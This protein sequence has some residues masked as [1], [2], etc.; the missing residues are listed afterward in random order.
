M[1]GR[2]SAVIGVFDQTAVFRIDRSLKKDVVDRFLVICGTAESA[3][4]TGAEIIGHRV[5]EASLRLHQTQRAGRGD[6]VNIPGK[7]RAGAFPEFS[8][9]PQKHFRLQFPRIAGQMIQ[10]RAAHVQY[11]IRSF[12]L[13][14]GH[15]R[16][17]RKHGS[18]TAGTGLYRRFA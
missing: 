11:R 7:D 9:L 18:Q 12:D 4:Q 14:S 13:Q 10:M 6:R 3:A 1:V 16:D 8:V 15:D 2:N 17:P 5:G